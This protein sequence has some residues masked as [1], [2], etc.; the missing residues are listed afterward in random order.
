[1]LKNLR[2]TGMENQDQSAEKST[3]AFELIELKPDSYNHLEPDNLVGELQR[4]LINAPVEKIGKHVSQIKRVFDTKL[5]ELKEKEKEA[6][7]ANDGNEIDF[8][9][10]SKS[11]KDFQEL[12]REY[13]QKK[14]AFQ[15][16]FERQIQQ[17]LQT[18]QEIIEEIKSLISTEE[19][20][21]TTFSQFRDLQAKWRETGPVPKTENDNLWANYHHH[22][23]RFYDFLDLNRELRDKDFKHNYDEKI[24]IVERA[25][26]LIN[27]DDFQQAYNELQQLHRIWKEEL[28]PV[29]KEHR[30]GIW[31]RFSNATKV[32]HDKRQEFQKKRDEEIQTRLTQKKEILADFKR[33]AATIANSHQGIQAQF[34]KLV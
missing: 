34:K 15:I 22:V 32:M 33:E 12:Y 8:H 20:I 6:F 13:R 1:M 30:A 2:E 29:S 14:E 28:G 17:N 3:L 27:E 24:K 5:K 31:E 9:F 10:Q 26:A 11:A 21:N 4:L 23:E 7:L 19:N 16:N 18:K 25:E